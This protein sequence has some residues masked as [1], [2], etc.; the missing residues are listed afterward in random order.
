MEIRLK[1]VEGTVEVMA[2]LES[3]GVI[4]RLFPG[5][6]RLLLE[7]GESK[8]KEVYA[9]NE[10]YGAHKLIAVTINSLEPSNFVYH[11]DAE[12]FILLD[13]WNARDLILTVALEPYEKIQEK[14][15]SGCLSP[16]DFKA[17]RC[18]KNDPYASFFT[19]NPFYAHVET[20]SEC[21]ENPPSFYVTESQKLDEKPIALKGYTLKIDL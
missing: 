17:I 21:S 20:C 12:D 7:S 19:M 1:P 10:V 5:K 2:D 6:D 18:K 15:D 8:W 11:S 16:S 9:A 14:I 13:D 4:R 3:R